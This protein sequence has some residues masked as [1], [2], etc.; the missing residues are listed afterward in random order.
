M[1][2]AAGPSIA[3][4][5][6]REERP[7]SPTKGRGAR[8]NASGRFEP[9][10]REAADDGWASDEEP[11]P[12]KTDVTEETPRT[13]INYVASPFVGFDRSIN[14]YRGCEHGCIYCFARP[15]HA[16]YG[17][18][19]GLDF[20]TKL[21][22]KPNAAAL[23]DRE[24]A[25]KSYRPR[26]IAIGTN[27]DPYQPIEKK[28]EIMRGVL[29][30]L[31]KY[32]H[33][34][35]VLTKSALITRDVD[36]LAPM[37]E[38]SI[39]KTMLSVTT[40]DPKLAR[41]MEPRAAA[42]AKRLAAIR[43]LKNAGVP[44]GVMTAPMIPGLNDHEMEEILE[45]AKDA[46]ADWAGYTVI[47]LPLEVSG[48]FREWLETAFPG[49]AARIMRHIRDMNGGR[50]YDV[51]WSRAKAPRSVFAKLLKERFDKAAKRIGISPDAPKLD[52]ELFRR[53]AEK[54]AQLT[55]F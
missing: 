12:L 29:A 47:R 13:I 52:P 20:E 9:L 3:S 35:S 5:R 42:P 44:V 54:T 34:V 30:V 6:P 22:A 51:E 17:L 23:L 48:L 4:R 24:L 14:P 16:Y 45:A 11:P 31:G 18:S 21:F 40:L 15:T 8:S 10:S 33:P 39:V 38:A 46:G 7:P 27:T 49:R 25:A 26:H 28:F 43:T 32:N 1:T 37:A 55:L 36:L 2:R 41:A 19:A 50:D 53:P